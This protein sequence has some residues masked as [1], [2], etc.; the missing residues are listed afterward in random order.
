MGKELE[1]VFVKEEKGRFK[2]GECKK[3]AYGFARNY[4]FPNGFVV[5]N[6]P[7]N[8]SKIQAISKKAE[9]RDLEIQKH[10]QELHSAIN[11]KSIKFVVN[12]H[13]D[14]KLYGSI[15]VSDIVKTMNIQ[16][17]TNLDRHDLR[18]YQPIKSVGVY[19]VQLTVHPS[20]ETFI[21]VHVEA[22]EKKEDTG[23]K[24]RKD[25]KS[26]EKKVAEL[27]AEE[28]DSNDAELSEEAA[29]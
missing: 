4:L 25:K 13:D 28:V 9:K 23:F 20:V 14:G 16:H 6:T 10:A 27:S 15:T 1:V 3:V 7:E 26:D 18:S 8:F 22:E 5:E 21:T 11:G 24:A 2:L 12:T 19:K 29:G 17:E